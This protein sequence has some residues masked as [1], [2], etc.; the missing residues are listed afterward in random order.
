[1][2]LMFVWGLVC[3]SRASISEWHLS[4]VPKDVIC[5]MQ[6]L[7]T[8]NYQPAGCSRSHLSRW[9]DRNQ[10]FNSLLWHYSCLQTSHFSWTL[11]E[12]WQ[13]F[14]F[15]WYSQQQD[16]LS[17]YVFHT[18]NGIISHDN[19]LARWCCYQLDMMLAAGIYIVL[20]W[21]PSGL[22]RKGGNETSMSL[23]WHVVILVHCYGS[24]SSRRLPLCP[25]IDW[26]WHCLS[27]WTCIGGEWSCDCKQEVTLL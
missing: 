19:P 22:Q 23:F 9:A 8:Q 21:K 2:Y 20:T 27:R 25:R 11:I 4:H 16:S 3:A 5:L 24:L 10:C 17:Y 26:W 14:W 6:M 1:M 18:T 15:H 13:L 7:N 12:W